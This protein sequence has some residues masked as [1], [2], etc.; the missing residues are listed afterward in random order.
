MVGFVLYGRDDTTRKRKIRLT[1]GT[2]R[3]RK[4]Y[5]LAAMQAVVNILMQK[6]DATEILMCYHA[7]NRATHFL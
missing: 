4:H 2:A 3:E 7:T 1:T 5:A 6:H